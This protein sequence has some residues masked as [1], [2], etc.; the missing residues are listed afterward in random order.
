VSL[1]EAN[2]LKT[3]FLANVSH[4]LRTP[5]HSIIG[6]A[7][8]LDDAFTGENEQDEKRRRYVH[9]IAT[10]SR[11]LLTMI[12]ELLDLAKIEAG[13]VDLHPGAMS[14]S[15]VCESLLNLIR[16][17][18]DPKNLELKLNVARRIP[19]VETDPGKVQQIIFNFLSNAVKFTPE[20]GRIELGAA[21][22]RDEQGEPTGVRIRVADTGPGI[23]MEHHETVFEKF[24]Q[25]DDSHTKQ[26]GG[27]GLGLAISRELA[28]LIDAR[29]ELDSDVGQGATFTLVLPLKLES[30]TQRLMPDEPTAE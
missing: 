21:A 9:N 24:R 29:I 17:Q 16:P 8:V 27:T 14:V 19:V 13:R 4:E 1:Y 12:N 26:F 20:G 7:D 15:D 30:K 6:F 28:R 25:I 10:A 2:R 22:V 18:A 3:D 23:A 5:L 11:S